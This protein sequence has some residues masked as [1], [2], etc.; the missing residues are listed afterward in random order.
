MTIVISQFWLGYIGGV[1]STIAFCVAL[2]LWSNPKQ[3]AA[4]P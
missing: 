2:S 1:L 4:K 3:K